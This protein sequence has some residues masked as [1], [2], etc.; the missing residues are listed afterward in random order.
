MEIQ[1]LFDET[2]VSYDQATRNDI[3]GV[4]YHTEN[5]DYW[6]STQSVTIVG[7]NVY[8]VAYCTYKY[9]AKNQL[10][11]I[12]YFNANLYTGFLNLKTHIYLYDNDGNK[13]KTVIEY[14]VINETDSILYFYENNRLVRENEYHYGVFYNDTTAYTGLISYTKYE[15]DNQGDLIKEN[16]YSGTNDSLLRY[17]KHSYQNGLNVKTETFVFYNFIGETKLR[18][19]RR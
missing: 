4:L 3:N 5:G 9:N 1:S 8:Y 17:S 11:E 14:P 6:S 16:Y 18:E 10:E 15:Y 12:R 2:Y 7:P 19:I 13:L